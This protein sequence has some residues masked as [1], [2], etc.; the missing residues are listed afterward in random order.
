MKT[1]LGDKVVKILGYTSCIIALVCFFSLTYLGLFTNLN[2]KIEDIII[3][4][5]CAIIF[6][7]SAKIKGKQD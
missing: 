6:F 5:I 1:V 4:L 3:C 7:I 2:I